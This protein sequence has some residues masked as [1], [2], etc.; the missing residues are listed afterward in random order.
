MNQHQ[1]IYSRGQILTSV[2]RKRLHAV[3]FRFKFRKAY[4]YNKMGKPELRP[5]KFIFQVY[6]GHVYIHGVI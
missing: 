4:I 5:N 1:I 6:E 2:K 3:G